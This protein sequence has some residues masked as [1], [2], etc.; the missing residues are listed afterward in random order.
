MNTA[1]FAVWSLN[2]SFEWLVYT[3]VYFNILAIFFL[4]SEGNIFIFLKV[5]IRNTVL[6]IVL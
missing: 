1:H 4:T 5:I 2:H 6:L 3:V